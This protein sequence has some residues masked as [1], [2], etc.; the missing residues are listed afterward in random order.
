MAETIVNSNII[1]EV[2]PIRLFLIVMLVFYHAFAIFSG[3]WGALDGYP[4]IYVYDMMDKLSYAC[5]L[6]TFVFISGYIFGGQVR[7]K[8]TATVLKPQNIFWKKFK[9]LIIPSMLFSVLYLLTLGDLSKS[10]LTLAYE[11][12]CGVGHMWFLPMLFWCFIYVYLIE[13]Y[14][15]KWIVLLLFVM[16]FVSLIPLPLRINTAM[17]Y[18][19]FFYTG[20][21]IQKNDLHFNGKMSVLLPVLVLL[22]A[23]IFVLKI[24]VGELNAEWGMELFNNLWTVKCLHVVTNLVLKLV[25]ASFGISL[26]MILSRMVVN[27]TDTSLWGPIFKVSES[28][29]GVYIFQQFILKLF[30]R[31]DLPYVINVWLY[32]W[33]LFIVSLGL[34]LLMT[35]LLRKTKI[36]KQLL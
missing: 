12:L 13:K 33:V 35:I 2:V 18:F 26:L 27:N 16:M 9:R 11:V 19:I 4:E 1:Y 34:S 23:L 14:I 24:Y 31:S 7:W 3:A 20:Y 22:F 32:P 6:E 8:G 5:L 29:F 17:Y 36:G 25:C 10:F 15:S 21:Y 30:N 28:C